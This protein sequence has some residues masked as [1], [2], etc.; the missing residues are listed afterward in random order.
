MKMIYM[1]WKLVKEILRLWASQATIV[2]TLDSGIYSFIYLDFR[3][4]T[5]CMLTKAKSSEYKTYKKHGK[6]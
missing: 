4:I 1:G 5:G 6:K 3:R 2:D